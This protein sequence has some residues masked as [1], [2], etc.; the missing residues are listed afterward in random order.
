MGCPPAVTQEEAKRKPW[1]HADVA[2]GPNQVCRWNL[3]PIP[4][5]REGWG[6]LFAA[7][8]TFARTTLASD[9]LGRRST[10]EALAV[11]EDAERR[12]LRLIHDNSTQ[13]TSCRF[14]ECVKSLE[15]EDV[16]TAYHHKQSLGIAK[17]EI[18]PLGRR[19]STP[20][21]MS[22]SKRRC[23]DQGLGG[24]VQLHPSPFGTGLRVAHRVSGCVSGSTGSRKPKT[25]GN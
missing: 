9:L 12:R 1:K 4:T 21:T 19:R 8:D 2:I 7:I 11:L 3:R 18:T 10:Q 22:R 20:R 5:L 24:E 16:Y 15:I 17:N 14:R 6:Y 25:V 13:L 23:L